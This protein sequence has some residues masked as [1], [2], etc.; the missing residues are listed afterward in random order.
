MKI[1]IIFLYLLVNLLCGCSH[2]MIVKDCKPVLD[3]E[4]Y[5]CKTIK[6]WE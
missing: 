3:D 5:I 4:K 1:K 2:S 6:P